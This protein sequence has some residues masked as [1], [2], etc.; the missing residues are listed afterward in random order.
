MQGLVSFDGLVEEKESR[1]RVKKRMGRRRKVMCEGICKRVKDQR[2]ASM[3]RTMWTVVCVVM[4]TG[5][6]AYERTS[7]SRKS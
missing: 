4:T 3:L 7:D 1:S 5:E 6:R 2:I